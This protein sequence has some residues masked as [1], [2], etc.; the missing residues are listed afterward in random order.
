MSRSRSMSSARNATALLAVVGTLGAFAC[1]SDPANPSDV[2]AGSAHHAT[3]AQ[4]TA[5]PPPQPIITPQPT[6]PPTAPDVQRHAPSVVVMD[7]PKIDLPKRE[8]FRLLD[9]GKSP[10]APLRYALAGTATLTAETTLSSRHLKDGA[11]APAVALPVVRDGF[12]MT[13]DRTGKL[14][15]VP[16][17]A[18]SASPSREADVY[19]HTWRDLLQNRRIALAFDD[20]GGFSAITFADDP[21]GAR[22][23]IARDELVQR[24]LTVVVPLPAEPVGAGA[25]WRVVTILRQHPVTVK[26]TA[27]YTLTHR[28][29]SGWTLHAKLQRVGEEQQINDPTLP[30]GTAAELVA[31]FRSLEGD[32]EVDP[33]HALLRGGSLT[34]ESRMHVRLKPTDQPASEQMIEDTGSLAFTLRPGPPD[35]GTP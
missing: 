19:L 8:S 26:Q 4:P 13:A 11:F 31:L 22:S 6:T 33:K 35:P 12:S 18:Q 5:A 23:A 2:V 16:Q 21:T 1:K 7:E 3:P 27:T 24:L 14:A 25:S 28:S 10:R 34:I 15:L 32:I 29:P 17:P 30:A 20:R 9:A